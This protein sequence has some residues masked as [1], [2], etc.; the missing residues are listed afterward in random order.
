MIRPACGRVV[1]AAQRTV[2]ELGCGGDARVCPGR[3]PRRRPVRGGGSHA[4]KGRR[5]RGRLVS[6]AEPPPPRPDVDD[7]LFGPDRIEAED[8]VTWSWWGAPVVY[9]VAMVVAAV[10]ILIMAV[11]SGSDASTIETGPTYILA[12]VAT[13][14]AFF[15][16]V[17][18]WVAV[19]HRT[20]LSI[21]WPP[22]EPL[23]DL[24]FGIP[25][26]VALYL[27]GIAVSLVT[28]QVY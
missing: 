26:G 25:A 10:P 28:D 23:R 19:V 13:E 18:F 2:L 21:L 16:T 15:G 11:A 14:L 5:H 12:L 7:R 9:L 6:A 27:V 3:S 20:S 1:E 22:K 24:A 17:L 8:E 4:G